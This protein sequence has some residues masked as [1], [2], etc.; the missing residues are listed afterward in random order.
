MIS[1]ESRWSY[2]QSE[3]NI[4]RD[5]FLRAIRFISNSTFFSFNN[6]CFQQTF[7]TP[8]GSPLSP[9][10]ADM[11]L[12]DLEKRAVA[13]FPLA[14]PFYFRCVDDI[15]LAVLSSE[16]NFVL[17]TFNSSHP[18][19]QFTMEEGVDNRLNFLDITIIIKDSL[20][21]FDWYH[22]PT[23]SGRYPNFGSQHPL[24]QKK[25]TI[26]E[27]TDR[28]FSPS[29]ISTKKLRATDQYPS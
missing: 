20:I 28:A 23:F 9:I 2:I 19:L 21:E 26:N 17:N 10:I 22:K 4:P 1:I 5:E 13:T 16:L 7:G 24:C 3:C 12:Q 14:L 29:E 6:F 8:M 15:V 25:G 11:V 18:R 27:L